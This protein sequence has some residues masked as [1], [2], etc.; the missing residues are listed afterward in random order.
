MAGRRSVISSTASG[1]PS[2]SCSS[3]RAAS[4]LMALAGTSKVTG[5]GQGVPSGSLPSAVTESTSAGDMNP[6]SGGRAPD[7]SSSRSPS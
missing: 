7:S 6:R 4:G 3:S 5:T 2:G 1:V